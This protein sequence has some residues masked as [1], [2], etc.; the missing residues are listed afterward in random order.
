MTLIDEA[1]HAGAR[2]ERAAAQL[3][4]TWRT[5]Q[6]W[7]GADSAI[8]GRH[9]P[10]PMPHN[11][12]SDTERA[13]LLA[14][15]NRPDYRDLS[16]W[17]IVPRLLDEEQ[18]YLASESTLYRVLRQAG[19]A[20]HRETS[21]P[22]TATRPQERVAT[23]PNQVYSWDITWMPA[24]VRGTFFYLYLFTDVWSRM[25]VAAEVHGEESAALAAG[26]F[27]RACQAQ[28]L[29]PRGLTLHS[30]NG[31]PMKGETMLATL[32][33]LGVIS[34]FSRPHVSDD[35]PYSEALFRTLKYRP[36]YPRQ[37]F[38][39]PTA[40]QDWVDGFVHWYNTVHR[41]SALRFVTPHQ[42]H[43]GHDRDLLARR[44]Q[45]YQQARTSHPER[46]S[47]PTRDWTPVATVTLN[48]ARRVAT[49]AP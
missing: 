35:N 8:D 16:P 12:L 43:Y 21:R 10:R 11:R 37:P 1:A 9:G 30:D 32:R 19:Q 25:I 7:R 36:S 46:W 28:G 49:Q 26:V 13:E 33:R 17:H 39:S 6:R 48:P 40:A 31:S 2:R 27:A 15:A 3:G 23:G 18:R 5:V 42:R 22:A 41:H 29:D 45:I 34:S 4:L 24:P 47:G 14:V 38:A 44:H 20:G